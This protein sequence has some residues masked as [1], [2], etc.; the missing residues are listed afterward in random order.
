MYTTTIYG[1]PDLHFPTK[2]SWYI[3][4]KDLLERYC[5]E[6]SLYVEKLPR[7]FTIQEEE[8]TCYG[9]VK[10]IS[11]KALC[12]K[13]DGKVV[14]AHTELIG[15]IY[16]PHLDYK[17]DVPEIGPGARLIK[18]LNGSDSGESEIPLTELAQLTSVGEDERVAFLGRSPSGGPYA[19][20]EI[21]HILVDGPNGRQAIY[22]MSVGYFE[23][24]QFDLYRSLKNAL[25]DHY[26]H[27]RL[28]REL[29]KTALECWECGAVYDSPGS[30][31]EDQMGCV[32][33][34]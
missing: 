16:T 9:Q 1:I 33:C 5:R 11:D 17:A 32:R 15:G 29:E 19:G 13:S 22:A 20:K 18:A 26:D 27:Q 2:T 7:N 14:F 28:M 3:V 30:V 12:Q 23:G 10:G 31:D 25:R 4:P 8:V 6:H 24:Y 21:K 34:N